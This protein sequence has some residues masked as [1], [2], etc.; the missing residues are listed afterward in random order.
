MTFAYFKPFPGLKRTT[1]PD[2]PKKF[3]K[4]MN[5]DFAFKALCELVIFRCG[6]FEFTVSDKW[7]HKSKEEEECKKTS[8]DQRTTIREIMCGHQQKLHT[9]CVALG[10][11]VLQSLTRTT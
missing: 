5:I 8:C 6:G 2:W 1:D 3:V 11:S 4:P 7:L 9:G 10:E